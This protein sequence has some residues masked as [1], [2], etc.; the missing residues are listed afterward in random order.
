MR[1]YLMQLDWLEHLPGGDVNGVRLFPSIK[2]LKDHAPSH[3][4]GGIV[5]VDVTF[6]RIVESGGFEE[7]IRRLREEREHGTG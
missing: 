4:Y 7:Q 6:T 2:S 1:A 5:E 3:P